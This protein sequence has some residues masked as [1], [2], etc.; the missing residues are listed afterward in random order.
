MQPFSKQ[1]YNGLYKKKKEGK[2]TKQKSMS[3][4]TC[5][6]GLFFLQLYKT[7]KQYKKGIVYQAK[8]KK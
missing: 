2:T 3:S 5:I 8:H 6:P 4:N 1:S 7:Q